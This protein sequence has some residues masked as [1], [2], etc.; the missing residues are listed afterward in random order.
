[1][2]HQDWKAAIL[3]PA[4]P[5]VVK[6]IVERKKLTDNSSVKVD[7]NDEVV[8]IKRVPKDISKLITDARIAKKLL[9]K[10]LANQLNLREDI[11]ADIE[12]GKAIYDGNQIARIKKHLGI[13]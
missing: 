5:Q 4:A 12:T 11:I 10:D 7:E 1:M 13:K 2:Q 3:K 8:Q 9:R 6:N